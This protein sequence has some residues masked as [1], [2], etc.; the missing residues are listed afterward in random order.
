[1]TDV[2]RTVDNLLK[3][4]GR[5]EWGARHRE[6]LHEHLHGPCKRFGLTLDALVRELSDHDYLLPAFGLVFEDLATRRFPPAGAN[7]I[8]DYLRRRGTRESPS[9]RRY[10]EALRDSRQ[11]L[12]EVVDVSPGQSVDVRDLAWGGESVRVTEPVASR[13]LERSERVAARILRVDDQH[14]FA[15]ATV[16]FPGET[17]DTLLRII[18]RTR[19]S[20]RETAARAGGDDTPDRAVI[21][22][23]IRRILPTLTSPAFTGIWVGHVLGQARRPPARPA[24]A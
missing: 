17:A 12:Y 5:E 11:G 21:D 15:G 10:L 13:Q 4:A 23:R 3:W 19:N 2:G 1:M 24:P 9:G 16:P 14:L 22:E 20:L 7:L 8:D 6:V 18:E